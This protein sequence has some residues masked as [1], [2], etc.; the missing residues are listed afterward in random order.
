VIVEMSPPE[1]H[2][3][4]PCRTA[5]PCAEGKCGRSKASFVN[6]NI[7]KVKSRFQGG[8]APGA[9]PVTTIVPAY[10][11]A[12][13][14]IAIQTTRFAVGEQS[15]L[16]GARGE[17]GALGR[18]DVEEAIREGVRRELDRREEAQRQSARRQDVPA[19]QCAEL[20]KRVEAVEKR[21]E[22]VEKQVEGIVAKL[23]K[24]PPPRTP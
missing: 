5:P 7:S 13:I 12:T 16:F 3:A 10:A 1:V 2:V 21:L 18:S 19:D 8:I 22:Q 4:A 17:A 11:T 9:Q 15:A 6:I 14:P 20:K 23:A 24:L